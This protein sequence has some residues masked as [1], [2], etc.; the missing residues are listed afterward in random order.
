MKV[1]GGVYSHVAIIGNGFDLNLGFKTAYNDF[2]QS[3]YF[4]SLTN[5]GSNLTRHLHTRHNLEN[6]IDIEEELIQYS[7]VTGVPHNLVNYEQ[8]FMDLSESLISYLKE[9]D[10][11]SINKDSHSFKLLQEIKGENFLI[12]DYNYTG[13][14]KA[15]LKYLGLDNKEIDSRLIKVHGSVEEGKIIFG[16]QDDANI[17]P[18]HI[19]LR[20][21]YPRHYKAINVDYQ[22]QELSNLYIFGHSLGIT[23]HSYFEGFFLGQSLQS[24]HQ[25]AKN[26]HLYYYGDRSYRD[27][28]MQL[29]VL[30]NKHLSSFKQINQFYSIDTSK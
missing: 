19:F 10:I 3:K 26:I 16:V 8:E 30:T 12:L 18:E 17:R 22:L 27:L 4:R 29:D 7:R 28:H 15:T 13:I 9:I 6:W 20:K 1:I 23:D 24:N 25:N 11:K 21:A 5:Q 14:T 2:V